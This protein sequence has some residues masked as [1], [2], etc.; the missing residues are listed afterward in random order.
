[1][2]NEIE[3]YNANKTRKGN[4]ITR[5]HENDLH[6]ALFASLTRVTEIHSDRRRR[7]VKDKKP[8]GEERRSDIPRDSSGQI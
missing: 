6:S 1:M 8:E 4:D 5:Y 2:R 7:D 3:K